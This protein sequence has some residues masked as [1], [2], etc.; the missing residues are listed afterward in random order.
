MG[1]IQKKATIKAGQG[2]EGRSTAVALLSVE[3]RGPGVGCSPLG[4]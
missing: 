4:I 1:F 3:G 2:W